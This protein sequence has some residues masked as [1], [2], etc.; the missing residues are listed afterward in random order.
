MGASPRWG[1]TGDRRSFCELISIAHSC[2]K[3]AASPATR[4]LISA[5]L[6]GA[7]RRLLAVNERSQIAETALHCSCR[8]WRGDAF[9]ARLELLSSSESARAAC[10]AGDAARS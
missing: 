1:L 5:I 4:V 7:C 9:K 8:S 10:R 2:S 6:P 3:A